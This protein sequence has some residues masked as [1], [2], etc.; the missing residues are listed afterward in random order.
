[1]G[2]R[3][4]TELVIYGELRL[5][6]SVV[7]SHLDRWN[8]E[9]SSPARRPG[10][11]MFLRDLPWWRL[12]K[13]PK[14]Y[15]AAVV[16]AAIVVAVVA[17]SQTTWRGQ[18]VLKFLLLLG[19]GF[20]S[21]AATPRIAYSQGG[22]VKDF[23]TVWVLPIAILLPP[24]YALLA[25][26]PLLAL[27]QWRVHRGL[28]YRRVFSAAAIGLGYSSAS[29]LFRLVPARI[30]GHPVGLG[31][32]ALTW[33]LVVTV[34]E[35]VGWVAHC[36]LIFVAI[37]LTDR[38]A[39]ASEMMLSREAVHSD[40]V[41]WDLGILITV[42][43]AINPVLA[44]IT[45]PTVLLLRRFVMHAQLV[46]QSRLD[47]K[48]GLLNVTTWEREAAAE[49]SRAVRTRSPLSLA[50]VDIDHFKAVNDTYGHLVGDKVLRAVTD[51]LMSQLRDYDRAG[52]FGG[53][54][55]VILLPQTSQRDASNIAERLRNHVAGMAVPVDDSDEPACVRL[56]ISVGV[57]S[58]DVASRELTDLMAAAD[59]ALYYA[60]QAGRN[61]THVFASV[62]GPNQV[63]PTASTLASAPPHLDGHA[64]AS[65]A[66]RSALVPCA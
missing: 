34:C 24:V 9:A 50:L 43:V 62:A 60:K 39:R 3:S 64:A 28:A 5:D 6:G 20:V 21:V 63:T 22:A 42:V 26:V 27:T 18:D 1:M 33:T 19:C 36:I 49:V 15:V 61:R 4:Y 56:T 7:E 30:A 40:F 35:I 13:A 44:V 45:V 31:V 23:L 58:M 38:S 10:W 52:R 55:F 29:A 8:M 46:A 25:P 14:T 17:G 66:G 54:E 53:E 59:A 12:P 51:A 47:A 16:G 37:K 2:Y 32:H 65:E 11:T 41:E 48:T 57:A